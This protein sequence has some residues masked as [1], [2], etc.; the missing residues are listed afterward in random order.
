[1]FELVVIKMIGARMHSLMR[2]PV[3]AQRDAQRRAEARRQERERLRFNAQLMRYNMAADEQMLQ[4][5]GGGESGPS[6]RA[7]RWEALYRNQIN[8][9]ET[10]ARQLGY[11]GSRALQI[12]LSERVKLEARIEAEER[13]ARQIKSKW[14]QL[15]RAMA[16]RVAEEA[17]RERE[18]ANAQRDRLS[19]TRR[20]ANWLRGY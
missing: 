6:R 10:R 2:A 7:Q 3:Q 14:G 4:R 16:L 19:C 15:S 11:V 9:E 18:R 5:R 12:P 20:L 1:M 8:R 13:K 17:Y